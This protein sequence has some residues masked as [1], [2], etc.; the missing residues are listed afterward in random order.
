MSRERPVHRVVHGASAYGQVVRP[1]YTDIR[2]RAAVPWRSPGEGVQVVAVH[3]G[4]RLQ[5]ALAEMRR[6]CQAY[7]AGV[8]VL[9]SLSSK[10]LQYQRYRVVTEKA[11]ISGLL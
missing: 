11:F 3:S 9:I 1:D 10:S 7:V 6:R 2:W 4:S 5:T 8:V